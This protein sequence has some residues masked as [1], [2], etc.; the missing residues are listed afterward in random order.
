MP[1]PRLL[2]ISQPDLAAEQL[3]SAAVERHGLDRRL[4]D[5]MFPAANWH[6]TWSDRYLDTP[7][8]RSALRR[9]GARISAQAFTMVLNRI[10]GREYWSFQTQG[11]P[12]GFD[13]VLES[14]LS[15]LL[16]E[17]LGEGSGH[18]PHLTL[19]YRAPEPLEPIYIT[20]IAWQVREVLLVVGGSHQDYDYE[21]IDRW[22][23]QTVPADLQGCL[24]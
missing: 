1:I 22:A 6:Q 18:T 9:V 17:G 3:M 11:R 5:A 21:I 2:L 24:F 15:A 12:P 4:G 14:V 16:Q 19:S 23:L 20:P 10:A 8:M 7:S 13:D